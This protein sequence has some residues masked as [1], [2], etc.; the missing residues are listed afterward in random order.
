MTESVFV[1]RDRSKVVE[2][3]SPEAA[4]KIHLKEAKRLGLLKEKPKAQKVE[5]STAPSNNGR[6]RRAVKADES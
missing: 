4:H 3:G 5:S 1:N 6:T 2:E